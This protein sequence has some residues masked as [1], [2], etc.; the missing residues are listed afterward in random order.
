MTMIDGL[1]EP[2]GEKDGKRLW[3]FEGDLLTDNELQA[4]IQRRHDRESEL[5]KDYRELG[6]NE[7]LADL[8]VHLAAVADLNSRG[9]Y[10]PTAE[11][12]LAACEQ[13]SA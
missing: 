1:A 2:A 6:L 13:V 12:Y 5:E 4:T 10:S 11:E 9:I 3:K 7:S 8:D